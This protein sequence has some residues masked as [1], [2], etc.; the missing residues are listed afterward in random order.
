MIPLPVRYKFLS[1]EPA[2]KMFVEMLKLYGIE[3]ILGPGDN[4][5]IINW[6][7]EVNAKGYT[8]D[9]VA[10]CGLCVAVA[11][12]R[13]GWDYE[14]NGNSLWARNWAK[15]GTPQEEAMLGD[16]LVFP[17]GAGGHVA[18]YVGED[19]GYYHVLGGNQSDKVSIVRRAKTP[20]IAIRRAPWKRFQP[21]NVRRITLG[22][23]GPISTKEI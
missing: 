14:P 9:A 17:R 16:V 19:K 3:E 21:L 23:S 10:W 11:A 22:A 8:N 12:K 15:W 13:G 5:I 7:K 6:A 4:P 18:L 2:P 20:I 1:Y